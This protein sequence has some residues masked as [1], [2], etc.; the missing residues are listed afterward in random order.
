MFKKPVVLILAIFFLMVFASAALAG[1][2]GVIVEGPQDEYPRY[3]ELKIPASIEN[4]RT[5]I[6]LRTVAET[7][8]FKVKWHADS[9]KII[10]HGNQQVIEMQ[11]GNNTALVNN[12]S[13][14]IDPAPYLM[15]NTTIVP[16]RFL[17]ESLGYSAAYSA[18]WHENQA[19]VYITPYTLISDAEITQINQANF[20]EIPYAEP[21]PGSNTCYKL[22]KNGITPGGIRLGASIQDVLKVYGVPRAPQRSLQ[23]ARDWSGVLNYWGTFIPQSDSGTWI[24]FEFQ[25]GRLVNM[26][27]NH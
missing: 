15:M 12:V 21:A 26:S 25:N 1:P 4:G 16:L 3:L 20:N 6:P 2:V 17:A 13:V 5:L 14:K 23:Y 27:I 22:K 7:L 8:G 24:D 9:R 11:I 10:V 19:D 18:T